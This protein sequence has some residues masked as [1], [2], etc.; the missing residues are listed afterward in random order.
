MGKIPGGV[1]SNSLY[2]IVK[3]KKKKDKERYRFGEE[4][5]NWESTSGRISFA[6]YKRIVDFHSEIIWT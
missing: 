1:E 6:F 2:I 5:Y 3:K 4:G